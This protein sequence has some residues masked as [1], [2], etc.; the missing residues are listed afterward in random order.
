MQKGLTMEFQTNGSRRRFLSS[1]AVTAGAGIVLGPRLGRAADINDSRV[2]DLV[3]TIGID[4]HNHVDVP[5]TEAEMPG[6]DIDLAGE[7][8]PSGLS[9]I[10][11]TFATDYQPGDAYD[12]FLKGMASMDRQLKGNGM[13]RSLS[14]D[15]VR[16]AHKNRQRLRAPGRRLHQPS[17][18]W[19]INIIWSIRD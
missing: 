4:T 14:P 10:C 16:T 8:K 6:P 13:K 2:T 18:L 1:V 17:A 12:R 5:L 9:A 15:D 3:A 19:R 11:M 7:M